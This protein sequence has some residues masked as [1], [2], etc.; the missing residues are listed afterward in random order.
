MAGA[1]QAG[2]QD[3]GGAARGSARSAR[4]PPPGRRGRRRGCRCLAHGARI[5]APARRPAEP[6]L[7]RRRGL[8]RV[9]H[10]QRHGRCRDR[11]SLA[12]DSP[13]VG[14]CARAPDR[15][16]GQAAR[17]GIGPGRR[18]RGRAPRSGRAKAGSARA[19]RSASSRPPARRSSHRSSATSA[20]PPSIRR[21]REI[22]LAA[23]RA[24]AQQHARARRER[25]RCAWI[26][27]ACG[28]PRSSLMPRRQE[29]RR[30]ARPR[31]LA[32]RDRSGSRRR[33]ARHGLRRSGAR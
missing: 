27:I 29:E 17:P 20:R 31:M 11:R 28:R 7:G 26:S 8:E 30:S 24:A 3:D 6:Q 32:V 13:A 33:C 25:R 23:A 16:P 9:E 22:R 15:P 12:A 19:G 5:I 10:D 14:R 21:K 1:G 2:H 18:C 4:I